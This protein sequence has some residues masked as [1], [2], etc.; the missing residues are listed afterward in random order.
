MGW[1]SSARSTSRDVR[2]SCWFRP[3]IQDRVRRTA[4]RAMSLPRPRRNRGGMRTRPPIAHVPGTS[5]WLERLRKARQ[6]GQREGV[7]CPHCGGDRLHRWGR[8]SGRQRYRC[9]GCRRTFSDFT[10]TALAYLKRLDRWE[11]YCELALGAA[12][13]RASAERL[14][15]DSSTC[16][17]WRHRLLASL[18]DSETTVLDGRA[19]LGITWTA[20]SE[21]G[22]RRLDRPPRARGFEGLSGETRAVWIVFACDGAGRSVGGVVG[23]RAPRAGRLVLML[24]NRVRAGTTL[25]SRRGVLSADAR[26]AAALG[27]RFEREP[28]PFAN[29]GAR[30]RPEP[31][32]LH[33]RRWKRWM[34]RFNGVATRYLEHYLVWFRMLDVWTRASG[35]AAR[36]M[37]SLLAGRFP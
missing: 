5:P 15:L 36:S 19:S 34:R 13:I 7:V 4:R 20:H 37:E 17:R 8:F 27:L 2:G 35:S 32:R 1:S 30:G 18:L 22:A 16:F 25:L 6:R 28:V 26:A 24:R 11:A 10:G 9:L 12:T 29:P 21:K 3:S 23:P 31:A 14:G 33:V